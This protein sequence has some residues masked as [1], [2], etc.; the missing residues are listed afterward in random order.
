[1]NPKITTDIKILIQSVFLGYAV[2][3]LVLCIFLQGFGFL[4]WLVTG[5][6]GL[7]VAFLLV[8]FLGLPIVYYVDPNNKL[9]CIILV[10]ISGC[11]G[12]AISYMVAL[13]VFQGN[14]LSATPYGGGY[15][16][17][18]AVLYLILAKRKLN[19]IQQGCK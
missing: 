6:I 18:I 12:V 10:V 5:M 15:A 16:V 14:Y 9:H 7:P 2:F 17:S 3:C 11:L 8:P 4:V 19:N 13:N 1:M